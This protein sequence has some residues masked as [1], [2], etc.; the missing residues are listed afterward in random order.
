MEPD[1][2]RRVKDLCD[3]ALELEES[4]RAEFL[5]HA[6]G[7]EQV[8][9]EVE[10]LLVHE[11][12][13]EH[14]IDSPALEVAAKVI[15]D[16]QAKNDSGTD[17]IGGKVSHYRIVQKL[18]AGGMGV[19]YKAEDISLGRFVALK[20]LPEDVSRD[21]QTLERFRR[22]A[23][24]TSALN[25]PNICTLHEIAEHNG[26]W[27]IVMEFLDGVTLKERIKADPFEI[28]TLVALAIE[29]ADALDAA[30]SE[31]IIH[32]DIKPTN[33]FL[34][35]R[36][37]AKILD[38]GLAKVIAPANTASQIAARETKSL[39][40]VDPTQLTNPGTAMG[41]IAYM[42]PEQ[43]RAKELDA[44]T[45]LFSF[46]AVLYEMATGELPFRGETSAIL[47][48][49]ILNRGPVA[50]V[51]FNPD[52]P[53][54][55]ER[56]INRALEKDRELRYQSAAEMRSELLRL[57]RD[58]DRGRLAAASSGTAP[59]ARETAWEAAQP[60]PGP[61]SASLPALS[62]GS[63]SSAATKT[64]DVPLAGRKL[65]KV[66]VPAVVFI[67][68]LVLA[69]A[70]Y[71]RSRTA[72]VRLT[73]KD[74]IV[75]ADF[76]NT[77]GDSIF[78]V[79]LRQ[80]LISQLEQS[81]FLSLVSDDRVAH[82]LTLLDKP[83]D[84][85]LTHKLASD[86]C[87]R[88]GSKA[89]I[90]GSISGSGNPYE[91]SLS[92]VDCHSGDVL[93]HIREQ[94]QGREALLPTLGK[95]A[96][97]MRSQL[98]ES[99]RSV[100]EFDAPPDNVT[101]ASLE[102][103]QAYSL[104]YRAMD[105]KEDFQGAI[106]M[107]E[108][109][110]S[111]DPN[112]AMAYALLSAN[113]DNIG[114][115]AKAAE[116]GR[117]AF[118]LRQR[119]SQRERYAIEAHYQQVVAENYEAARQIYE[120]WAQAYPRDDV[121]LNQLGVIY[122]RLGDY[123]KALSAYQE[124]LRLDPDSAIGSGNMLRAYIELNR[125]DEAKVVI[126]DAQAHKS[127][128]PNLHRGAYDIAFL[129]QDASGME[130]EDTFLMTLPGEALGVLYRESETAAYD[131]Q[132]SRARELARRVIELLQP[133]GRKEAAGGMEVQAGLREALI[134]NLPL[135]KRQAEDALS[136]T[137]NEYVQ[138]V[139]AT[140]LG[141]AGDAARATQL[142]DSLAIRYP[143]NTSMQFHYLPMI[144]YAIA[145]R[146]GNPA[147]ALESADVDSRF[148]L[149]A[150]AWMSYVRLYPVY[151]RGQANLA[152]HRAGPAN[153]DFQKILDHPGLVLNEPIGALA[154]LGLGRAY[155]IAGDYDKARTAYQD[156]LALWKDADPDIPI[157]KEA[158]AEYAKLH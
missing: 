120:A 98:G 125:L 115:H 1:L 151:I 9:R 95:A 44:R 82:T 15:A 4:R 77:T 13:A 85:R 42:S 141:L 73:D 79:T 92:A 117:K 145:T 96:A 66:A 64:A 3:R 142:A 89:T 157:L 53:P 60:P 75:I 25:H 147:K 57:K 154:H 148:D 43:A 86:V 155:A 121:P 21:P 131:G 14:F 26:R 127:D 71:W 78:D 101:S 30:H 139:A 50:P 54:E 150:P 27:F 83:K 17:L 5:E 108:R 29:I 128:F 24:A 97:R 136:L 100:Q 8:R 140:V 129:Q 81:P 76:A 158:K 124:S 109:A 130:R 102:A 41:T 68:A 46:G 67:V 70:F 28:D 69:G 31:G 37:H 88:N 153:A 56:V 58:T 123:D 152:A 47:F 110:T 22:E 59:A 94:A 146:K 6:C 48:D 104:G 51:R 23:R 2:W 12:A 99:L 84:S 156:F 38:F 45:D 119:A 40:Y 103:L 35:K 116:T 36:G 126:Q 144:R 74:T 134:G 149:G 132:Y 62:Q 143:Q 138:A 55:L 20:F 113:D 34:T 16:E 90:E 65:W 52:I 49:A 93:I 91:L 32:R 137:D 11:K 61:A 87:Q 39:S 105:V 33:I 122:S 72:A 63:P 10:S 7:D 106:P 114:Q 80:G 135:A 118:E 107:F 18:G 111:L 112:F 133:S 19:V